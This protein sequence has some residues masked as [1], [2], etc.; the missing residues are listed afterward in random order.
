MDDLQVVVRETDGTVGKGGNHS[1]PDVA[2]A[3]V[4]PQQCRDD[5]G[6]DDEHPAHGRSA[7]FALMG[8]RAIFADVLS[9]LEVPQASH[10]GWSDDETDEECR[11]AGECR[12]KGQVAKDSEWADMKYDEALL[13]EQPVEQIIPRG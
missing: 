5:C 3:E 9:D 13:I 8:L 11:E 4:C 10:H 12:A 2:V 6:H 7:G 1:D